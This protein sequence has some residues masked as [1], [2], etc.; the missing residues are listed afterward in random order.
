VAWGLT[1]KLGE[2]VAA[3]TPSATSLP[4]RERATVQAARRVR[5]E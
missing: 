1:D 2:S 3:E 5:D 4:R